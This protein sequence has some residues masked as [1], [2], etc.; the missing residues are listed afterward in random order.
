MNERPDTT[1]SLL[2]R[3]KK[4]LAERGDTSLR[5]IADGADVDFEW[6]KSI[7]Y[8]RIADPGVLKLEKLHLYLVDFHAAK[9]FQQRAVDTRHR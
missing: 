5:E 9:R 3:T 8:N 4:L 1:E 6:V 2:D 7:H